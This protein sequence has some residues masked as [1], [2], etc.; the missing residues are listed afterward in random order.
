MDSVLV[1]DLLTYS[2]LQMYQNPFPQQ[3]ITPRQSLTIGTHF[4]RR[5]Y[6]VKEYAESSLITN[7]LFVLA[8]VLLLCF[9]KIYLTFH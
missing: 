2:V 3:N 1:H 4:L 6:L 8:C 9:G 5:Y 7:I